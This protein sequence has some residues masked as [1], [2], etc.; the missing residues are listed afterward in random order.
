[1]YSVE[2]LLIVQPPRVRFVCFHVRAPECRGQ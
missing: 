1:V 2:S